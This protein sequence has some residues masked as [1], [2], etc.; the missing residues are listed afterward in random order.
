LAILTFGKGFLLKWVFF[1]PEE[2]GEKAM[3][4]G[5]KTKGGNCITKTCTTS[6]NC[7]I[8]GGRT[9]HLEKCD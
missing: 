8:V 6:G 5:E 1:L 7:H 2:G 3:E 9:L 4:K